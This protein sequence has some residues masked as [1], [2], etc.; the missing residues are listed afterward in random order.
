[1]QERE[2]I[3]HL[4]Q[5][6]VREMHIVLIDARAMYAPFRCPLAGRFPRLQETK[7]R[8]SSPFCFARFDPR[9]AL[10]R[11]H[12]T[13]THQILGERVPIRSGK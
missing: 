7:E 13:H 9:D 2:A 4:L 12:H 5:S 1:M 8:P 10:I 11:A 3:L 6:E